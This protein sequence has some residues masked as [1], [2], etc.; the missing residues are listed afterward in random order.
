MT[1]R[2]TDTD[3]SDAE[4]GWEG[5]SRSRT[6]EG[7]RGLRASAGVGTSAAAPEGHRIGWK[8]S[9]GDAEETV[10][11]GIISVSS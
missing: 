5:N 10:N 4:D 7:G 1:P 3:P 2:E 8:K 11:Q 9:K 6:T